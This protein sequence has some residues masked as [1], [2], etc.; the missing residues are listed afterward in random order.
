[1]DKLLLEA[2]GMLTDNRPEVRASARDLRASLQAVSERIDT[3]MEQM[4][5]TSRNM[6]EFSREIRT[7]PGRLLSDSPPADPVEKRK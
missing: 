1:M 3:I 4:E 2:N 6:Q 7:N 5:S